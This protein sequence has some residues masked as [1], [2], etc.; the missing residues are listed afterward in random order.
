MRCAI[1]TPEH[2]P[3][4]LLLVPK[5]IAPPQD[6]VGVDV[7]VRLQFSMLEVSLLKAAIHPDTLSCAL[8]V[9]MSPY[10]TGTFAHA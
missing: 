1:G 6:R 8:R 4:Y 2:K 10:H 7:T 9:L 5:L 3:F